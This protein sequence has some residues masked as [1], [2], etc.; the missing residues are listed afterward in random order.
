[1]AFQQIATAWF[2]S[3]K[4]R[5]GVMAGPLTD[6][7]RREIEAA[8]GVMPQG[9]QLRMCLTGA[10]GTGKSRIIMALKEFAQIF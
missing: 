6:E 7:E 4:D 2:H 1:M 10:G 8:F 9:K 5:L 3:V